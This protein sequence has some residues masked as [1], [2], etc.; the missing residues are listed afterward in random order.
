[1]QKIETQNDVNGFNY[2]RNRHVKKL[3]SKF[4]MHVTI[5]SKLSIIQEE[6]GMGCTGY[7]NLPAALEE[8][9]QE[10]NTRSKQ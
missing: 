7:M 6:G 9:L 3:S 8:F 10:P 4:F 2:T 5:Y 1:M